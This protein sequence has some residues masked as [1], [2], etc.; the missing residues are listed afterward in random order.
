MEE[1]LKRQKAKLFKLEIR[2][3]LSN[4]ICGSLVS[5]TDDLEEVLFKCDPLISPDHVNLIPT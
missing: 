1:L 2:S 3:K 4:S 5:V